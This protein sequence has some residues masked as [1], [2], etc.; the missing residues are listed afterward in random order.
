MKVNPLLLAPFLNMRPQNQNLLM[1]GVY[2]AIETFNGR[3]STEKCGDSLEPKVFQKA[4]FADGKM[5][6][7]SEH[8]NAKMQD[9]LIGS[10]LDIYHD[11]PLF[12]RAKITGIENVRTVDYILHYALD[13]PHVDR[14][15]LPWHTDKS[16]RA[17]YRRMGFETL[18]SLKLHWMSRKFLDQLTVAQ[19][20]KLEPLHLLAYDSSIIAGQK[21][22]GKDDTMRALTISPNG[23]APDIDFGNAQVGS[24]AVV[25]PTRYPETLAK[26]LPGQPSRRVIDHWILEDST[27]NAVK[28]NKST[29]RI[30]FGSPG[31]TASY[32]EDAPDKVAEILSR[33][34]RAENRHASQ[35]IKDWDARLR[36][37]DADRGG[38]PET[39]IDKVHIYNMQSGEPRRGTVRL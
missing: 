6:I 26:S 8:M 36:K 30:T 16:I 27:V 14:K 20:M 10:S 25:V 17:R 9:L 3:I 4:R 24:A 23:T 1:S 2:S 21:V 5:H 38:P 34:R 7:K 35:L 28:L 13:V 31:R 22:I 15:E 12:H 18:F 33:L 11:I 37:L 32:R 39:Q 29:T 19:I